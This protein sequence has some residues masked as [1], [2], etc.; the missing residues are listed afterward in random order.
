MVTAL[1]VQEIC[2]ALHLGLNFDEVLSYIALVDDRERLK[3]SY[4]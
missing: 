4:A 3:L 2:S 1:G